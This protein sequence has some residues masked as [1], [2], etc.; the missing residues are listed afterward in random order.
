M[1]GV[2]S[3][4]DPLPAQ[5]P[6]SV[7]AKKLG[8]V[9]YCQ[10]FSAESAD[11]STMAPPTMGEVSRARARA[12]GGASRARCWATC[13]RHHATLPVATTPTREAPQL[14]DGPGPNCDDAHCSAH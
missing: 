5:L 10:V 4:T 14:A 2:V 13:A 6:P 3:G 7:V 8:L 9:M 12:P 1:T 11:H